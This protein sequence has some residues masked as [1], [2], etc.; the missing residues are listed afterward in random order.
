MYFGCL[1]I[2]RGIAQRERCV[3]QH[4]LANEPST[5]NEHV[6]AVGVKESGRTK[7]VS[8]TSGLCGFHGYRIVDGVHR[9]RFPRFFPSVGVRETRAKLTESSGRLSVCLALL[10]GSC[11]TSGPE[12]N[13]TQ[14]VNRM[15]VYRINYWERANQ[16]HNRRRL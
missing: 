6:H 12:K 11:S 9:E 14:I 4:V 5:R 13:G 7:G 16:P 8:M 2:R 3:R 10:E 15:P 1:G